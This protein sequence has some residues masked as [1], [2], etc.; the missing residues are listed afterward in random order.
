MKKL[1]KHFIF[2][3]TL[4]GF[5]LSAQNAVL[6]ENQKL[7]ITN[8]GGNN[9]T[10]GTNAE[11]RINTPITANGTI[12]FTSD[13]AW[14]ILDGIIPSVAIASHIGYINVNGQ[15]AVN[16]VNIKVTNYLRGCI[17]MPHAPDFKALTVYKD[18]GFSGEEMKLQP[19]TYYKIAQL[20]S[21]DNTISS[22][23]LQKGYMA[24]FAQ[25]ENGSGY[26]KVFIADSQDIQISTLQVGLNDK[27]SFIRV[28]PW[29][30]TE[31]KGFGSGLP[32]FNR[33][34]KPVNLTNS[35][36]FY[37]WG[38]TSAEDLTNAEFVPMK[39]NAKSLTDYRWQ[40][41]LDINYSNHILGFNEPDGATQGNMTLDELLLYWPKMMES[42][43]RLGSPA[44][45]GNLQLL[46]DFIDKCD[47]LNYRVDFAAIH[48]YGEGTALA[49]YNKCK[50]V[51]DRTGRPV[52]V[53]E[54]N[55][56]GTWTNSTPTYPAIS[57][58]IAEIMD[59]YDTEGIIERYS[60]FNFDE[61]VNNSGGAQNRAIFYTPAI[62]T[63]TFT[64]LGDTYRD[65]V[66]PMAFNPVEQINLLLKLVAPQNLKITNVSNTINKL[67]W[68]NLNFA[69]IGTVFIERASGTGGY[70]TVAQISSNN[71][72]YN[73]DISATGLVQY[74]Y[75]LS[76]RHA[77]F[78]NSK[79]VTASIDLNPNIVLNVA[80][81]K[82]VFASSVH[83]AP[84]PATMAVDGD[85]VSD[86]SRWVTKA[87]ELPAY[88]EIDLNGTFL[89]S[90]LKFYSGYQ[91]YNSP[92][93]S[94]VFQYWNVDRW[95]DLV[96]ETSNIISSYSK[97]FA[98]VRTN[99]VRLNVNSTTSGVARF[100]EIE[101]YGRVASTLGIDE[102][103][104]NKFTIYPNPTSNILHISGINEVDFL[105][106][107]DLNG[108]QLIKKTS[109]NSVDISNLSKGV[110]FLKLNNKEI[111]KFIKK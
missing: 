27:V 41:I 65:N 110:Y 23:K 84:Y 42:G 70:I 25:N 51:H 104:S 75:R 11:L 72:S 61:D 4:V 78:A 19:Y 62:P 103:S 89:I 74:N 40:E 16:N 90:Q 33:S 18:A 53:T 80:L 76:V 87:G 13:S 29:R 14:I 67:E 39:W 66:S 43:L 98:E 56:G 59:K 12:N 50:A 24:T 88:I 52:W 86:A 48:D 79:L 92:I 32:D 6:V 106:I 73:D 46:Y 49:F 10:L 38:T 44:P 35:G 83:S 31:K 94:F 68:I 26:S 82:N 7:T 64:P 96:T 108:K 54:F 57:T 101:I 5:Q 37:H 2:F 3:L 55:S 34:V 77:G 85:I 20:G 17:I 93:T 30:Y 9:Y 36:W 100:Y 102:L 105:E 91:G 95:E 99:K 60:I 22:F 107:L 58:R 63:Y 21:F 45:A 8:L 71:T 47:E 111:F 1:A 109:A 97:N 81:N 15:P 28:F 69:D